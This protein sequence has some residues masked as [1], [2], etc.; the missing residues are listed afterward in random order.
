MLLFILV[1]KK[2]VKKGLGVRGGGS[3]KNKIMHTK[4][5]ICNKAIPV[6][7]QPVLVVHKKTWYR[8]FK[9]PSRMLLSHQS[10]ITIHLHVLEKSHKLAKSNAKIW[11]LYCSTK[12]VMVKLTIMKHLQS[13]FRYND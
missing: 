2:H 12:I 4:W 7:F 10:G 3:I 11:A 8:C 9:M 1:Y 5:D 13:I 6:C